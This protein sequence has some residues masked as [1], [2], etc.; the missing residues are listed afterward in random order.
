M[1]KVG[2]NRCAGPRPEEYE[3]GSML[4]PS[5]GQAIRLPG[6]SAAPMELEVAPLRS[7][8]ERYDA[9]F[10]KVEELKGQAQAWSGAAEVERIQPR[11]RNVSQCF[12]GNLVNVIE[13][14]RL[15]LPETAAELPDRARP[16]R[17]GGS[18]LVGSAA[19]ETAIKR[20]RAA[21]KLAE[22]RVLSIGPSPANSA[23]WPNRRSCYRRRHS[24][25]RDDHLAASEAA[26]LNLDTDWVIRR[27]APN[28]TAGDQALS[29]LARA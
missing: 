3:M 12:H 28:I 14:R 10:G 21:G 8:S 5:L 26:G 29:G 22:Y 7:P 13:R 1:R 2:L 15:A 23:I 16:W 4:Q 17:W 18:I 9:L 20:L 25:R 27:H 24:E 11:P 19:T 6:V